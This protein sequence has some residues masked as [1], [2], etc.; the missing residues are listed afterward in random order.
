MTKLTTTP[1]EKSTALITVSGFTDETGAAVIPGTVTWTLTD[2]AGAVINSREN[3]SATAGGTVTIL[4]SGNDL[5]I[6]GNGLGRIVTIATT[7][8]SDNGTGLTGREQ[9]KFDLEDYVAVS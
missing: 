5:A 4:L 2:I 6:N 8:D 9:I 3:V 1:A 7:Y